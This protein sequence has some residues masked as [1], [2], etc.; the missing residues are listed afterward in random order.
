MSTIFKIKNSMLWTN[1]NVDSL[2]QYKSDSMNSKLH[3][4]NS[5]F[6]L[7]PNLIKQQVHYKYRFSSTLNKLDLNIS[8]QSNLNNTTNL[9]YNKSIS[10]R[11]FNSTLFDSI[12]NSSVNLLKQVR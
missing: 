11:F 2:S 4:Y 7:S 6:V 12:L 1:F 5:K 10:N 9:N 3:M 8:S